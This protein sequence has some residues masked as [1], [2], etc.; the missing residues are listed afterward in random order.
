[1]TAP[2]DSR[3]LVKFGWDVIKNNKALVV[4]KEVLP[5]TVGKVQTSRAVV[6]EEFTTLKS[7]VLAPDALAEKLAVPN[8]S[9][10]AARVDVVPLKEQVPCADTKKLHS[11]KLG[12]Q[13]REKLELRM[14]R[15]NVEL[16]GRDRAE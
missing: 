16:V 2:T 10:E 4:E 13:F 11:D 3:G 8:K 9:L 12:I 15:L 7:E 6:E 14:V 1:M 5:K